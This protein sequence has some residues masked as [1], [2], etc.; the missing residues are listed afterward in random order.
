RYCRRAGHAC[1]LRPGDRPAARRLDIRA[2]T[3][4]RDPGGRVGPDDGARLCRH[5][6]RARRQGGA[7]SAQR[8]TV[9]HFRVSL[10]NP[11][12]CANIRRARRG[13]RAPSLEGY[14]AYGSQPRWTVRTADTRVDL[15]VGLRQYMLHVYNYMASALALTGIVAYVFANAGWYAAIRGT[16]LIWVIMLA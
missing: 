9:G 15:D 7:L 12:D 10:E 14:M 2:R 1:R 4:G 6:A 8:V 13:P 5:L 3:A 16:P 11:T